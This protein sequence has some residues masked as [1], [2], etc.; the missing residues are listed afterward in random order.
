MLSTPRLL[1]GLALTATLL[2]ACGNKNSD[3]N[4]PVAGTPDTA[5]NLSSCP[6]LSGQYTNTVGGY[7]R[8]LVT[9]SNGTLLLNLYQGNGQAPYVIDGCSHALNGYPGTT[10]T[11]TCA[12]GGLSIQMYSNGSSIGYQRITP[13]GQGAYRFEGRYNGRNDNQVFSRYNDG[14]RNNGPRG[15][16]RRGPSYGYG[17]SR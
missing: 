10:Y 7:P 8:Q 3:G 14:G 11:G 9:H 12:N 13:A 5:F 1:L 4:S 6:D 16:E 15:G 2:T 17:G